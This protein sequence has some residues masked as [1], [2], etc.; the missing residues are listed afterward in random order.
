MG[1]LPKAAEYSASQ[2][3]SLT[4]SLLPLS[5]SVSVS[6]VVLICCALLLNV[7]DD[8]VAQ[9]PTE[10]YSR[11]EKLTSSMQDIASSCV[12]SN[13][14]LHDSMLKATMQKQKQAA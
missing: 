1:S 11:P 8:K 4:R 10:S 2:G 5:P 9:S 7:L 3:D 12:S 6:A 14:R 13:L